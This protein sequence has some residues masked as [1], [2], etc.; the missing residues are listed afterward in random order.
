MTNRLTIDPETIR[1]LL[2]LEFHTLRVI[3]PVSQHS[4]VYGQAWH[5]G[6]DG[7]TDQW[8][9]F[10]RNFWRE[11]VTLGHISVHPDVSGRVG[12]F[13]NARGI[14]G[15]AL[16]CGCLSDEHHDAKRA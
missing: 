7:S 8:D 3:N 14:S 16:A 4:L 1:K 9:H 2:W 11:S 10:D 13:Q 6:I 5:D 12:G 15:P